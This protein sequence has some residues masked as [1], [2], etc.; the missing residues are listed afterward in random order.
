MHGTMSAEPLTTTDLLVHG[1]TWHSDRE[2]VTAM[3]SVPSR[4]TSNAEFFAATGRLAY[5]LRALGVQAGDAVGS[6]MW[7]TQEHLAAYFAVPG[8]GAVLHTINIRLFGDQI[9]YTVN[10]AQDVA[11]LV[12]SDLLPVLAPLLAK[13]PTVRTVIVSGPLEQESYDKGRIRAVAYDDL[14]AAQAGDFPWPRLDES[15]AATICYTTGTTGDPKGVAYSHRSIWLHALSLCTANAVALSSADR[16]MIVVPMFH[17]NAWGY[18][19]ATFWAGG[20][21]ILSNRYLKAE[22]I[23]TLV[24]QERP[25]FVNGVPTI[26]SDVH[27]YLEENPGH[28]ISSVTRIVVGGA[29][30]PRRLIESYLKD[31]GVPMLQGWGMT[32]TSPLVTLARPPERAEGKE[33]IDYAMSQG[34]ILPGV[35]LRLTNPETGDELPCN[36]MA[37]GEMELRGPWVATSYFRADSS[38][39][40][41]DGWLRTG[42][43]GTVDPMG[44]V[45]LTDRSKDVI[46]SGGEWISSVELET[47]LCSHPDVLEAAVVG[48]PDPRWDERPCPVL[49]LREGAQA[50]PADLRE[51]LSGQVARWWLP[52]RWAFVDA[53]PRTSVGKFDKKV[54]RQ[55]LAAGEIEVVLQGVAG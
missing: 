14:T 46:K 54:I 13:M 21:L 19:H 11:I 18:P 38:G 29:P 12:D 9:V 26:W 45:R 15:S 53:I 35:S 2:V 22:N 25:T 47:L 33:A 8:M 6:F 43:V 30:T 41:R 20:S 1:A 36:G 34:R 3:G 40:F 48:V 49:V 37:I 7:N 10:H 31:Y 42:D 39:K 55:K 4:R 32:E 16:G 28:D 51:W 44:F 5:A 24:E 27:R 50:R 52:E 23:V 17:A